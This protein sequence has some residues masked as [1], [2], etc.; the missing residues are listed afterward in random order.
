MKI[1]GDSFKNKDWGAIIGLSM[2]MLPFILLP[3]L[4]LLIIVF[5]WFNK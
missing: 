3:V 2:M 1:F 5:E 4:W